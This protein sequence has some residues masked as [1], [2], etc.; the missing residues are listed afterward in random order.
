MYY[1]AIMK[2]TLFKYMLK[3]IAVPFLLG[4]GVFTFVLLMGRFLKLADLVISKGVPL[5]DVLKLLLYIFPSFSL[6]TIPMAFLLAML[7]AFGRLSSDSEITAIKS[8]GISLYGLLPPILTF[9]AL[10][11]TLTTFITIYALPW[12]NTAFKSLLVEIVETRASLTMKEKVFNDDFPGLVI[13]VDSYRP[14]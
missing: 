10:A 5:T 1:G 6:V 11:S 3:E 12:G 7:L 9:A 14:E 8:S 13:Y 2:K 4:I